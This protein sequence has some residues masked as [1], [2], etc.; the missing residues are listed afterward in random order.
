MRIAGR[1]ATDAIDP[2]RAGTG[3]QAGRGFDAEAKGARIRIGRSEATSSDD[4]VAAPDGD[5]SV[6]DGGV[7]R[8]GVEETDSF[9]VTR[10]HPLG[11]TRPREIAPGQGNRAAGGDDTL[12]ARGVDI[13]AAGAVRIGGD[14]HVAARGRQGGRGGKV[15]IA[16]GEQPDRARRAGG[17]QIRRGLDE[18]GA[19]KEDLGVSGVRA[20]RDADGQVRAVETNRSSGVD[21]AGRQGDGGII[22]RPAEGE[23]ADVSRGGS[24]RPA[25]VEATDAR[26]G[27]ESG[28]VEGREL[29]RAGGIDRQTVR[30]GDLEDVGPQQHRSRRRGDDRR[31]R[32][33]QLKG[34]SPSLGNLTPGAIRQDRYGARP[35]EQLDIG[36]IDIR[37]RSGSST[38]DRDGAG[39]RGG[40]DDRETGGRAEL[41]ADIEI[42][43]TR[44]GTREEDIAVDGEVTAAG[45]S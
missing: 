39:S 28:R 4:D 11:V 19:L 13:T 7:D 2:D 42:R 16:A 30:R 9:G 43:R 8:K 45:R 6:L 40:Q 34:D 36:E 18:T 31:G 35:G 24:H 23:R 3:I 44:G 10:R 22:G 12:V 26:R 21:A 5:T 41:G 37:S 20:Q 32:L 27:G 15:D 17:G 14:E 38:A 29:D 33:A 25:D 1:D